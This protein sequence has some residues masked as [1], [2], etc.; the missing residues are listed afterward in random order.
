V[1]GRVLLEGS[2]FYADVWG[3][4]VPR[5]VN[6]VSVPENS[7]R[8]RN[9]GVELGVTARATRYLELVAGYAFL[10][11]RLRDY[12]SAV[13]DSTGTLQPVEFGGKLLP[14]VPRHRLTGEARVSPLPA[15][16]LGVQIEWQSTVYVETGNAGA[17]IWYF[18][19]PAGAP[20]QQVP[21]RAVPARALVHLN[22]AWRL[23]PAT[24]FGSVENLFGLRY[25]ANV[26]ANEIFGRFYEAGPPATVSVGL[27][28]SAWA[29]SDARP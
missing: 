7:S 24:L 2:V 28:L 1:S 6:N 3:E 25:A 26:L 8:S 5:T 27:R 21:F 16:D 4:F 17:G 20:V 9:I 18:R 13:L 11:L 10:D 19:P 29:T 22:A 15:L 23:G 12:T 14:A